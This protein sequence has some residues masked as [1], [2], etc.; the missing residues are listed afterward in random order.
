M[1][2]NVDSAHRTREIL[3][4]LEMQQE[5]LNSKQNL[6]PNRLDINTDLNLIMDRF[7][8]G[9]ICGDQIADMVDTEHIRRDFMHRITSAMKVQLEAVFGAV[10][11]LLEDGIS[12]KKIKN[13]SITNSLYFLISTVKVLF[14]LYFPS[15]QYFSIPSL[16]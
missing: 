10:D 2:R 12:A 15:T 1:Q 9:K 3:T 5:D 6:T 16:L 11:N 13:E 8:E 4:D 7:S 14:F